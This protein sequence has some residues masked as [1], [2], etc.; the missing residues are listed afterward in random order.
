MTRKIECNDSRDALL[1]I[2]ARIE[3][4]FDLPQLKAFGPLGTNASADVYLIAKHALSSI[5]A[6]RDDM[7]SALNWIAEHP[8]EFGDIEDFEKQVYEMSNKERS[9]LGRPT[10][11]KPSR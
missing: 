2:C 4:V 11:V 6:Q 8:T 7:L 10:I 5:S 9:V 3:G 1:A